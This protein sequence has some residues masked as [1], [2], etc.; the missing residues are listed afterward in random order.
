VE[1]VSQDNAKQMTDQI[2]PLCKLGISVVNLDRHIRKHA[3][4]DYESSR[5]DTIINKKIASLG[6]VSDRKLIK[7][8][9]Q[10]G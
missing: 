10:V 2:C 3:N 8:L 4:S 5:L 9:I 7:P 6:I 1:L